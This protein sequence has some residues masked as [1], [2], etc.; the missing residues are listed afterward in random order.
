MYDRERRFGRRRELRSHRPPFGDPRAR[1]RL[2]ASRGGFAVPGDHP[3]PTGAGRRSTAQA[4]VA[5]RHPPGSRRR[6]RPGQETPP[7]R[8]RPGTSQRARG[9]RATAPSRAEGGH[10]RG[11]RH[12]LACLGPARRY[13]RDEAAKESKR[14]AAEENAAGEAIAISD[15]GGRAPRAAAP[16]VPEESTDWSMRFERGDGTHRARAQ[17]ATAKTP[18][19]RE[20]RAPESRGARPAGEAAR[21]RWPDDVRV[22]VNIID[23]GCRLGAHTH[24][25]QRATAAPRSKL[26]PVGNTSADVDS[27]HPSSLARHIPRFRMV[28]SGVSRRFP[29]RERGHRSH[30]TRATGAVR[31]PVEQCGD[32]SGSRRRCRAR[33]SVS[34]LMSV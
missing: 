24:D 18:A 3:D 28:I 34:R 17:P 20:Q 12:P 33:R 6:P 23:G 26:R 4:V 30:V 29:D 10:R 31:L 14:V 32:S 15:S 27:T 9:A 13:E 8:A 22:T 1:R 19:R 7:R 5:D 21:D 16:R 11:L 2:V 25:N